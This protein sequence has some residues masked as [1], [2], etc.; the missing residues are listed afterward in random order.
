MCVYT[1]VCVYVYIYI[2]IHTYIH[3]Y[4][5]TYTYNN[6]D[7]DDNNNHHYNKHDNNNDDHDIDKHNTNVLIHF[8]GGPAAARIPAL[9]LPGL[10]GPLIWYDTVYDVVY[11]YMYIGICMYVCLYLYTYVCVYIYIYINMYLASKALGT[12]LRRWASRTE[13]PR[14][15]I[16]T[17][18]LPTNI[19]YSLNLAIIKSRNTNVQNIMQS[20]ITS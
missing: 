10:K 17:P 8:V 11:A 7:N 1:H 4:T 12:P 13:R 19:N 5:H 20:S 15:Q 14:P 18:S 2:Y 3:T 16:L 6:N 9:H